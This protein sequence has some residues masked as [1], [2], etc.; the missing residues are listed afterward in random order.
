MK[1]NKVCYLDLA[2]M[3]IGILLI[4]VIKNATRFIGVGLLSLAFTYYMIDRYNIMRK[5]K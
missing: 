4:I 2:V 1:D 3:S 5:L